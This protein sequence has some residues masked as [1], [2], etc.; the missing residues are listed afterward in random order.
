MPRRP[1]VFT[2]KIVLELLLIVSQVIPVAHSGKAVKS[3][4]AIP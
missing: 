4:A 2:L 3:G 1:A